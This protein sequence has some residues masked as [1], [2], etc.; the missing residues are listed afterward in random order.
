MISSLV[1]DTF[2]KSTYVII[3]YAMEHRN[4]L[5]IDYSQFFHKSTIAK[6]DEIK[7][8]MQGNS[9]SSDHTPPFSQNNFELHLL[10]Q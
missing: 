8:I 3:K 10:L 2:G 9:S 6:T 7:I 5:N 4:N 1:S